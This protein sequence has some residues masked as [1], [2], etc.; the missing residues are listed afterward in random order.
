MSINASKLFA[1][2]GSVLLVATLVAGFVI[3]RRS[4]TP[5]VASPTKAPPVTPASTPPADPP[6]ADPPSAP[7]QSP[8]LGRIELGAFAPEAALEYGIGEPNLMTLDDPKTYAI[9]RTAIRQT[10]GVDLSD[11]NYLG[12]GVPGWQARYKWFD[13]WLLRAAPYG[14]PTIAIEPIGPS[15]FGV[16]TDSAE[17]RDLRGVFQDAAAHHITV[18]VRFASECNLMWSPYS[19]YN[20]PERIR[21]YRRSVRWFRHYMP[22]NIRLVF[23]PLINTPFLRESRQIATIRAMYAPGDYDRIGGTLYATSWLRPDMGYTWYYDFMTALDHKTRFQICELG[24][25]FSRKEDIIEFLDLLQAGRWPKVDRV[26]L[27]AGELNSIAISNHGHFG[28]VLPG[29]TTSYL[30]DM[31]ISDIQVSAGAGET[32]DEASVATPTPTD[33]AGGGMAT[34]D[35]AADWRSDEML[36][37]GTTVSTDP[38]DQSIDMLVTDVTDSSGNHITLSPP[39]EKR[40]YLDSKVTV[41]SIDGTLDLDRLDVLAGAATEA[42]G[43]DEGAG[44]PLH[45]S[46][47]VYTLR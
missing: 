18:W 2:A 24:G 5:A 13:D 9:Y 38:T 23:S 28:L 20:N 39:R 45:A 44:T 14:D 25:S 46:G 4:P 42:S 19:V 32:P 7:G 27:F 26:N 29:Q 33:V 15:R 36:L 40:V 31:L 37:K 30:R 17:M 34:S 21:Q 16:F 41:V 10:Y 1:F 3:L 35:G 6:T 11:M 8:H 12:V 22:G 47:I 43:W